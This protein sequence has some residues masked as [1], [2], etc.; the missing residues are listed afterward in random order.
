MWASCGGAQGLAI[1]AEVGVDR[2]WDCPHCRDPL[3]PR[4]P[5]YTHIGHTGTR[6]CGDYSACIFERGPHRVRQL[7]SDPVFHGLPAEFSVMESHCGQ[8]EWPPQGWQLIATAGE[9]TKTK[10]QCLRLKDQCIY[11]AQF[12]IEMDGHAGGVASDHGQFSFPRKGSGAAAPTMIDPAD[13]G[14][15]LSANRKSQIENLRFLF[16]WQISAARFAN[17]KSRSEQN[18]PHRQC[19][20]CNSV[21]HG[22]I[23]GDGNLTAGLVHCR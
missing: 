15:V 13:A 9:G 2:P 16:P 3:A 21:Q 4:T 5:I 1:L 10:T 18:A 8:I 6:P 14:S 7:T 20:F 19:R 12:H 17:D 22:T 11:A 23:G